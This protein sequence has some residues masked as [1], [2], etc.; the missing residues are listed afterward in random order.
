VIRISDGD[1][2]AIIDT[3]FGNNARSLT[4]R[5]A[6]FLWTPADWKA[7]AL[8]GIP[9]LAPWANRI[10]SESY[11]ANGRRYLLNPAL[12]NLRYDANHLPIHGL[13]AFTDRWT[14]MGQDAA[15]VTSRL[16]FWRVPEWM[17]QFPFAHAIEVTH[18]LREGSLQIETS[19][20]NLSAEAMPLC[21]GYHPYFQLPGSKRDD[22]R[23]H[24]AA[25]EQVT[26]SDL[27]MPTGER[28]PSTLP[29]RV[30]LAGQALDAVFTALSGDDFVLE[31]G[32]RQ[33]AVKY[34]A[35]YTVA[36][37]YAP[38]GREFVCFEPMTALTNAFNRENSGLQHV[39]PGETWSESFW[40]RPS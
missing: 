38:A 21:V 10:D 7:P 22:W 37:V 4:F 29:D 19:I 15:S 39:A 9:L 3:S 18:R 35:K 40:I 6:E 30:P 13:V 8:A 1:L 28:Q 25:C 14:V 16:E 32:A 23:V 27:L 33:L 2:A 36:I 34:G 12:G 11:L 20:E 17:A 24:V 31:D 5:G 26:L